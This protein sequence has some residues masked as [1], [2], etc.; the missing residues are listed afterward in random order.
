[1]VW[2]RALCIFYF[3]N[4]SNR[5]MVYLLDKIEV[6]NDWN[7]LIYEVEI[8]VIRKIL[9]LWLDHKGEYLSYKVSK[10]LR[11]KKIVPQTYISWDAIGVWSIRDVIKPCWTW[12]DQW[13]NK[14]PIYFVDYYLETTTCHWIECH[15]NPLKWQRTSYSCLFLNF[16]MQGI[17]KLF[18]TKVRLVSLCRLSQRMSMGI[19]MNPNT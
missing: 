7:C 1:M 3:I 2:S 15:H 5:C 9:F 14:L 18:T 13:W 8:V 4:D 6:W 19:S 17:C 11:V 12:L 10:Y 16:G